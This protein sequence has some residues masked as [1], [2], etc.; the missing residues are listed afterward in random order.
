MWNP[1]PLWLCEVG[2]GGGEG[3]VTLGGGVLVDERGADAG[4]AHAG[5]EFF[6]AGSGFGEGVAA[7]AEVVEVEAGDSG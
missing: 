2:E 5:H 6:G 4:V 1:G 3:L 7:V